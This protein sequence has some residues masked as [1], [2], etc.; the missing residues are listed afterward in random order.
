[1]KIWK[2]KDKIERRRKSEIVKWNS[3]GKSK[4]VKESQRNDLEEVS[5]WK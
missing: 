1:V 4:K 5:H 2:E 3:K